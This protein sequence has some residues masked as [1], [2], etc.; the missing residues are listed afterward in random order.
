MIRTYSE[1]SKLKS[2][3]ERFQYL[4]IGGGV[5]VDTFG[6]DRYLNQRFYKSD[7]WKSLRNYIIIRDNGCDL[8]LDDYDIYGH[9]IIHHMNPISVDDILFHSNFLIDPEYLVCTQLSTHNAIHYGTEDLIPISPTI[10]QPNDT[11]PWK[12]G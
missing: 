7:E 3:E 1:L 10:R 11:C 8:G 5:G 12:K 6:H 4:K 2:F 9:I